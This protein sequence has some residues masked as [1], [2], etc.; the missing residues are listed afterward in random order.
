VDYFYTAVL[1][2]Q[3]SVKHAINTMVMALPILYTTG[4]LR[5]KV[6]YQNIIPIRIRTRKILKDLKN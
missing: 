3:A 6:L 4:E 1:R 5:F 2:K